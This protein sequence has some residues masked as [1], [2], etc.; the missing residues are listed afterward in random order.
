MNEY[1]SI[2]S[3]CHIYCFDKTDYFNDLP[4]FD[5]MNFYNIEKCAQIAVNES[6]NENVIRV[7]SQHPEKLFGLAYI[8]VRKMDEY[9]AK[10]RQGV[11]DG[12]FRGVKMH[13]YVEDYQLD[14]PKIYPIY[15]T[16]LELDIPVLFHTGVLHF[17]KW[18]TASDTDNFDAKTSCIGYPVQFGNVLERYKD[19][20]IIFAHFGGNFY[21]E[22]LSLCERFD[23]AYMD[24]AWLDHYSERNLPPVTVQSWIE[25]AVKFLGS[26]KILY[27]GEDIYPTDIEKCNLTR[28]QKDDIL[29]NNAKR[30]YKL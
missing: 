29:Y 19:L 16:C 1:K 30:L 20:K 10:L 28:A 6:D 23:N 17:N 26:Q 2:D 14:D 15:E 5:Y 4:L 7:V 12:I 8:N 21:P 27:G 13:P 22:F 24:T 18:V 25:H 11:K 3:H 9:L